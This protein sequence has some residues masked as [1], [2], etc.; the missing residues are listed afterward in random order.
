MRIGALVLVVGNRAIQSYNWKNYKPLGDL[1]N[2]ISSLDEYECDEITI[3]FPKRACVHRSNFHESLKLLKGLK[4]ISPISCGGGLREEIDFS[5]IQE[6]PIERY[7]FSSEFIKPRSLV[8]ELAKEK[9][10][11]Q[12]IQCMLPM[13]ISS[14]VAYV[15]H[16][17]AAAFV[18]LSEINFD[19]IFDLSD[20]IIVYDLNNEGRLNSFNFELLDRLPS[21]MDRLVIS[22]GIGKKCIKRAKSLGLSA[23]LLDNKTLHDEN[24]IQAIKYAIL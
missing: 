9:C 3:I 13:A 12:A 14:D 2:V 6:L 16:S 24:H 21:V 18:P 1:Q 22:G 19:R 17:A 7:V 20:E 23:V 5:K 15:Y 10:G 11:K 8:V 4:S